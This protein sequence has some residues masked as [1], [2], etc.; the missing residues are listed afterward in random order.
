M[1]QLFIVNALSPAFE[2]WS[3]SHH[4]LH[5]ILADYSPPYDCLP[6]RGTSAKSDSISHP[7]DTAMIGKFQTLP[8]ISYY[9]KPSLVPRK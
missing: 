1:D 6:I 2:P 7:C 3:C 5:S 4:H 8:G 9:R